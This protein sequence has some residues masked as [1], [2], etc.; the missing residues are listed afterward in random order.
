MR[1]QLN[2]KGEFTD[3]TATAQAQCRA[4]RSLRPHRWLFDVRFSRPLAGCLN[5][6]KR[7][8]SSR[9][10]RW[11]VKDE[12]LAASRW[13]VKCP[14]GLLPRRVFCTTYSSGFEF[15][16]SLDQ[17]MLYG[18]ILNSLGIAKKSSGS[19]SHA[20]ALLHAQ[21]NDFNRF[22]KAPSQ[23]LH[24]PEE[25]STGDDYGC[26]LID[27]SGIGQVLPAPRLNTARDVH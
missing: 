8:R 13:L 20:A 3:G 5:A 16:E 10:L 15:I 14:K 17:C 1:G 26:W 24:V 11:L 6:T 12:V 21:K 19:C 25:A 23:E 27:L 22:I 4:P 2:A 7:V 18:V 9:P